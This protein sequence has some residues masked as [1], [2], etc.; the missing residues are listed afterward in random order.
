M[1][2]EAK[3]KAYVAAHPEFNGDI[4]KAKEFLRSQGYQ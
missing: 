1:P 4:N 2:S 3:L